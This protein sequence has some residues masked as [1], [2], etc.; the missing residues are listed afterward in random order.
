MD[1]SEPPKMRTTVNTMLVVLCSVLIVCQIFTFSRLSGL[2]DDLD[3]MRADNAKSREWAQGELG[4]LR[5]HS[6]AERAASLRNLETMREEVDRAKA[7]ALQAEGQAKQ[8]AEKTVQALEAK[9]AA[10]QQRQRER[11]SEVAGQL[12]ELKESTTS[13]HAGIAGVKTDVSSVRTEVA[14][15][16]SE[17]E[18]TIADLHRVTGDMGVMSGYIATNGKEIAAL[19]AL[20]DRNY[21]EFTLPKNKKPM[22]VGNIS[23]LLKKADPSHNRFSVEVV[24]DDRKVEKKDRSTNE[25]IQFFMGRNRLPS[26]LVINEVRKNAVVGYLATPKATVTRD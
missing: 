15:T 16:R 13:A 26:E 3:R 8:E 23:L 24:A 20:G 2:R 21:F 4:R 9:L 7:Q 11:D 18:K 6:T 14:N 5:E 19:K 25:P 17:L 10:A 12:T 22:A 1:P